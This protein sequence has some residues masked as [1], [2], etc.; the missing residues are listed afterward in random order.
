MAI[1]VNNLEWLNIK[2]KCKYCKRRGGL[3]FKPGVPAL[4]SPIE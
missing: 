1:K 4:R 3:H 2:F